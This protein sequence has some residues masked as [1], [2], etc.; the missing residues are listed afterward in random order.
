[1]SHYLRRESSVSQATGSRAESCSCRMWTIEQ[2][3]F[4]L[5]QVLPG[6]Q[7]TQ[8]FISYGQ[9]SNDSL[10]QYYGFVEP[11]NPHDTYVLP[12]LAA[13]VGPALAAAKLPSSK[14]QLTK[15]SI[16]LKIR[17]AE[18]WLRGAWQAAHMCVCVAKEQLS[19]ETLLI[20]SC[21]HG[22]LVGRAATHSCAPLQLCA[23]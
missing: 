1:M 5:T 19:H 12:D 15:C 8:V 10:L 22:I 23:D 16:A 7:G 11:G 4:Q 20:S 9:Q 17:A 3:E 21:R 6:L 14:V 2:Q 18:S 13:A